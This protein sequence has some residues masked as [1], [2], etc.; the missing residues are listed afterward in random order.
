MIRKNEL[1][2][3][4]A[5]GP[6]LKGQQDFL[7]VL[8]SSLLALIFSACSNEGWVLGHLCPRDVP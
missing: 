5:L 7:C 2:E 8:L 3:E 6:G 1:T 4:G